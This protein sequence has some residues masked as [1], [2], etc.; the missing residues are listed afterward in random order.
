MVLVEWLAGGY[1][2]DDLFVIALAELVAWGRFGP[3]PLGLGWLH[4]AD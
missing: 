1:G 2:H 3:H 4:S